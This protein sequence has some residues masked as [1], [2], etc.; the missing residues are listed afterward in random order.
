MLTQLLAGTEVRAR[1]LDLLSPFEPIVPVVQGFQSDWL[2][3]TQ[4][5]HE[6]H[7]RVQAIG[8]LASPGVQRQRRAHKPFPRTRWR[9]WQRGGYESLAR[10][11]A[12]ESS[13]CQ[14]SYVPRGAS[15]V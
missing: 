1:E 3:T 7:F 13:N 9:R 15:R 10:Y 4:Q 2:N 11:L 14:T 5:A 12:S 6:A 8:L